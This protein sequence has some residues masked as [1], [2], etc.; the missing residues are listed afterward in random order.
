VL[1][2]IQLT[3]R[4][5]GS[6]GM[7]V[8]DQVIGTFGPRNLWGIGSLRQ[9]ERI[10]FVSLIGPGP[11]DGENKGARQ[12]HN[13]AVRHASTNVRQNSGHYPSRA[14]LRAGYVTQ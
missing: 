3:Y 12:F 13:F 11:N 4:M 1:D 6:F 8:L 9:P 10:F 14:P 5:N 2:P 7:K